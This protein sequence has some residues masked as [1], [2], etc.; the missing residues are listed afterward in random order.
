MQLG[1]ENEDDRVWCGGGT[2]RRKAAL[3]ISKHFHFDFHFSITIQLQLLDS[4]P[5]SFHFISLFP[6]C[7]L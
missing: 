7:C 1:E 5:I 6:F 3:T 4:G 2:V